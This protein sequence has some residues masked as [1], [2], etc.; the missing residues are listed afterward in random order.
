MKLTM[1]TTMRNHFS[2]KLPL[3]GRGRTYRYIS[4]FVARP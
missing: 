1:A 3:P 4:N 2:A